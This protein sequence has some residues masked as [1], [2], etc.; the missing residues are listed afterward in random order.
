MTIMHADSVA[1]ARPLHRWRRM[2][3][4][5]AQSF[6]AQWIFFVVPAVYLATNWM[7]LSGLDSYRQAT[8]N[9]LV[10]GL[11][12]ITVPAGLAVMLVLRLVQFALIE[13]PLSPIRALAGELRE[14]AA[15]PTRL[16]NGLPVFAAMIFFNKAMVEL[17]PAIPRIVPFSW[18]EWFMKL[19]RALHF[20]TDPWQWLQPVMGFDTVTFAFNIVYNFWFLALFGAWFWFG[21]R[22][23]ADELRTRFFLSY[24]I[25]W[26]LGGG[27][28]AVLFSSAGPVYYSGI[29]FS[30]DPFTGLFAY[31]N[32]V[33]TRLTLWCL[34]A[35]QLLWDG[36][37]GKTAA[38]GISAFP[39][40]H[41][42]SAALF[43]LAFWKVSRGVGIAFAVYAAAILLGSVHLG[44]HYAIDGYAGLALAVIGWWIAGPIARWH[45]GLAAT[46]RYNES[47]AA[48]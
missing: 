43:A 46:R 35:Q 9:A 44:W 1:V 38:L 39:S 13:K 12:T 6:A 2:L 27:L 40:M 30:P 37:T 32:D 21:F 11:L 10:M 25:V 18:D 17:K 31:L 42:A 47:L 7:M 23:T 15:S 16:I 34:D 26:W 4:L 3:A 5:L 45:T 20:G 8:L 14:L 48:L 29:G 28:L 41:N 36:Y 24:M 19:D 33:D 22:K